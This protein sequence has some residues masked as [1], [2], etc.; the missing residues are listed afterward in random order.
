[1]RGSI[2]WDTSTFPAGH[3]RQFRLS[4][5]RIVN[6]LQLPKILA[7]RFDLPFRMFK[8]FSI[9]LLF[10]LL[11]NHPTNILVKN[12]ITRNLHLV[13]RW[14]WYSSILSAKFTHFMCVSPWK[15]LKKREQ[16]RSDWFST[17]FNA[18]FEKRWLSLPPSSLSWKLLKGTEKGPWAHP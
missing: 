11:T 18:Y 17:F 3:G 12:I 14:L 16:P 13:M 10:L 1:M 2:P 9:P 6:P 15:P 4:A 5:R 8:A 7:S